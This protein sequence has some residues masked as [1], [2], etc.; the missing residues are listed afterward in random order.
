PA[1]RGAAVSASTA[2]ELLLARAH[3]D[4]P[5]LRY[6]T[7]VWSW[8]AVVHESLRRA[9]LARA[10][11]RP[12]PFHIGVLLDNVPD[13]LF[14]L[15]AGALAGAVVVGINP[16]RR[17]AELAR[18]ITFTDCQL[19]VTD[20][21]G[22]A[23]LDALDLGDLH[24]RTVRVD[25]P[26]HAGRL[27]E[28]AADRTP[29]RPDPAD[30]F[31]L[32]FTSGTTGHPKAVRCSQ[33]RL[34][35]IA[36]RASEI[37][38][39]ARDDVCY[40]PMP[41]FHGNAIMALWAPAAA[42]GASLAL[43][44]RFSATRFLDDV[45]HHGATRFTYVGKALAYVLATPERPDDAANPL[46]HGFGTEASAPDR[47]LF[48]RRFGC[49]LVEGYGSSEGGASINV[50]PDTPPGSLG[51]PSP[52]TD[53]VVLDPATG[54]E[55]PRA[56]FDAAG[57][58]RNAGEAIGEIVNRTGAR[59]FEGYYNNPEAD[60]ERVRPEG[61]FTGDLGYRDEAGFFYFAG[62]GGDWLR[63]DS[64]NF[65]AA[66]VERIL[67]RHPDVAA[68]AVYAVPDPRSGDEVMATVELR[69]GNAFD[70]EAFAAFLGAQPDLGTKWA[71][72][73]VR[74][75]R[76]MPLTATGK[77]T[78]TALAAEGWRCDEPVFWSP[79]RGPRRYRPLTDADRGDLAAE[80]A[81]HGRADLLRPPPAPADHQGAPGPRPAPRP[82]R[83]AP[84]VL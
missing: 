1:R 69:P 71:P 45:R 51:L 56:R 81:R 47:T 72:R 12:G 52:G 70:P 23:V 33:G 15:G 28:A 4:A 31:L 34:A 42:V 50:T 38:G 73:F 39:F 48:S 43:A 29:A 37:Y 49:E 14:W 82:R 55:C 3:D 53:V 57:A 27:E 22:A 8:R 5:G 59:G 46:R 17:G 6:G 41:L 13:Y 74:L 80:F 21:A 58:L 63:V 83:E 7:A 11:R 26:G 16:T 40:C 24:D 77:I 62:R 60:A 54:L 67:E 66:P 32:L 76:S 65:A 9:A 19:L 35:A 18:D 79:G 25:D 64:E 68:A 10:L 36:G 44:G 78:K 75:A 61:Y 84:G 30:L 20:A 2:A